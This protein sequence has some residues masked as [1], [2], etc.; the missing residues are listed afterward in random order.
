MYGRVRERDGAAEPA[1]AILVAVRSSSTSRNAKPHRRARAGRM[2]GSSAG[3]PRA[4]H[5]ALQV[6]LSAGTGT[7]LLIPSSA[8]WWPG[9]GVLGVLRAVSR[10]VGL[11]R[12]D[13]AF[14][15]DPG[16]FLLCG[17][18]RRE[19]DRH[20]AGARREERKPGHGRGAH[21]NAPCTYSRVRA[22]RGSSK[23]SLGGPVLDQV[24][25]V[26]ERDL[27]GRRGA[28]ARGCA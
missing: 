23:T 24:A 20:G 13:L 25:E 28:P 22:A 6:V 4:A 16:T 1:P 19:P 27:V 7:R 5:C 14:A 8:C 3:R 18:A 10:G 11:R 2:T 15:P 21:P 9:R 12:R 17:R 26:H